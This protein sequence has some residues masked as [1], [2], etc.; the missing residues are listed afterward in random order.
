[1]WGQCGRAVWNQAKALFE[2]Y[3]PYSEQLMAWR[4]LRTNVTEPEL[5][6]ALASTAFVAEEGQSTDAEWAQPAQ[7]RRLMASAQPQ[8]GV[9]NVS[10]D[11]DCDGCSTTDTRQQV[12]ASFVNSRLE[13]GACLPFTGLQSLCTFQKCRTCRDGC[14]VI[15]MRG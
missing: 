14:D 1:M 5:A 3:L 4:R 2:P 11:L 7:A 9:S 8:L 10:T 6:D 12:L 15:Q 13:Q